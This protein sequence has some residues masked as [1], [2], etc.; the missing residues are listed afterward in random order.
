VNGIG[1]YLCELNPGM[2]ELSISDLVVADPVSTSRCIDN[3]FKS[4]LDFL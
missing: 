3:K 4:V 1:A 2:S